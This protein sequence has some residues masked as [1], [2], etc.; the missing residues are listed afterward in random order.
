MEFSDSVSI[1]PVALNIKSEKMNEVIG[2]FY[3]LKEDFRAYI[4]GNFTKNW[5][6]QGGRA[7]L[8]EVNIFIDEEVDKFV[9]Y[10]M[11]NGDNLEAS[12]KPVNGLDQC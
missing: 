2:R 4:N 7:A 11:R 5:T 9:A 6:T 1:D 10:L 8:K 12:K 3:K